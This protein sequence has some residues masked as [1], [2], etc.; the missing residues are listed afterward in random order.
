LD[1]RSAYGAPIVSLNAWM[2]PSEAHP[3]VPLENG[4]ILMRP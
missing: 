2:R 4:D 3:E 1:D